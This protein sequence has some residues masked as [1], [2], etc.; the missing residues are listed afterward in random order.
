MRKRFYFCFALLI[1][2]MPNIAFAVE[3]HVPEE[4]SEAF[5][6][7]IS[8]GNV[9]AAY[10]QLFKNSDIADI[11]PKAVEAVKNQTKA[12]LSKYGKVLK[13]EMVNKILYGSSILKLTYVQK[14]KVMPIIWVFYYYKPSDSWKLVNFEFNDELKNL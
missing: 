2:S 14:F 5:L 12:F 4:K 11:R 1:I 10:E 6:R 13:I 8:Q 7:L 9:S 3:T